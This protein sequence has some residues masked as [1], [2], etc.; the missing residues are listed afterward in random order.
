MTLENLVSK[1]LAAGLAA[2]VF[3][4][5]WPAHLPS[6]G[7]QWLV[8]R[9]L[10]WTLAFE[11]LVLA[12][13]PLEQ[14]VTRALVRRRAAVQARRVRVALAAAPAT[15]RKGGALLLACTGLLVPALLLAHTSRPER[16]RVAHPTTVVR[17]V[18]VRRQVVQRETV[19]VRVPAAT[20]PAGQP[21][22]AAAAPKT[23]RPSARREPK[24][25]HAVESAPKQADPTTTTTSAPPDPQTVP[26]PADAATAP[27]QD[28]VADPVG[29]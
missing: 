1:V 19:V 9:G 22:P 24:V 2:G 28:A 12:F 14:M 16:K 10:A 17:K 6:A 11:V 27:V 4:L 3:L 26:A 13:A 18:V 15:A 29:G 25:E 21:S 5:W 7:A 8:L 23:A 20:P